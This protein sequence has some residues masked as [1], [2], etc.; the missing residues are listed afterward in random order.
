MNPFML[1][2]TATPVQCTP[3]YS[4]IALAASGGLFAYGL[5]AK[6]TAAMVIGGLGAG[7]LFVATRLDLG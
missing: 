1:C 3:N 6:S 5:V 2:G 4:M 7:L